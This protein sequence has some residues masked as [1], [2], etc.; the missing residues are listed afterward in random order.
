M[1]GGFKRPSGGIAAA[2]PLSSL[3]V[4]APERRLGKGAWHRLVRRGGRLGAAVASTPPVSEL[5]FEKQQNAFDA[6]YVYVRFSSLME[7]NSFVADLRRPANG[8]VPMSDDLAMTLLVEAYLAS[9]REP[10]GSRNLFRETPD[11]SEQ[12]DAR[13]RAVGRDEDASAKPRRSCFILS[14]WRSP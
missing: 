7:H 9:T 10:V 12:A 4:L 14:A 13:V 6:Q 2:L 3:F 8:D 11:Q 5:V 1:L